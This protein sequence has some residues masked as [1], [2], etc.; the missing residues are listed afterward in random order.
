MSCGINYNKSDNTYLFYLFFL[1][2][3]CMN[4][5]YKNWIER[6]LPIDISHIIG[7]S[8]IE[9]KIEQWNKILYNCK[10]N[11]YYYYTGT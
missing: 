2:F 11:F 9:I 5:I 8:K 7:S 1:N 10:S 4:F 6:G 3:G